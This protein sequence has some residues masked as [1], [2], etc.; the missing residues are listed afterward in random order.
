MARPSL[1][2]S[3]K[4][5]HGSRKIDDFFPR[6]SQGSMASLSQA[7][8]SQ[9]TASQSLGLSQAST[10]LSSQP[11]SQPRSKLNTT[12]SKDRKPS[13][14][15]A[16][17]RADQE[18]I[19]VS[20]SHSG[21]ISIS[22]DSKSHITVSSGSDPKSVIIISDSSSAENNK[23]LPNL[24][25]SISAAMA[26]K[27][28]AKE[29]PPT[30]TATSKSKS[31][32]S[33][34][35]NVLATT[36]SSA[37][38]TVRRRSAVDSSSA[39]A[40]LPMPRKRKQ[41]IYD[42]DSP[43][44]DSADGS[45]YLADPERLP[46]AISKAPVPLRREDFIP[47]SI[48]KP[49]DN[50]PSS[51]D[52]HVKS[53]RKSSTPSKRLRLS[54]PSPSLPPVNNDMPHQEHIPEVDLPPAHDMTCET[55]H[56]ASSGNEADEEE[57]PSSQSD[58]QELTLPKPNV[59]DPQEVKE[60][61]DHWRRT[62]GVSS[63]SGSM[64]TDASPPS[65]PPGLPSEPEQPPSSPAMGVDADGDVLQSFPDGEPFTSEAFATGYD[66]PAAMDVD[67][68]MPDAPHLVSELT[69]TIVH[70]HESEEEA[71]VSQQLQLELPASTSL[72]SL[73]TL[74][75]GDLRANGAGPPTTPPPP[76]SSSSV[77]IAGSGASPIKI[78]A[79]PSTPFKSKAISESPFKAL[80]DSPPSLRKK[81][82][83]PL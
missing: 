9:P 38:T 55:T 59:K 69:A 48:L 73:S 41:G 65:E 76:A 28:K 30:K 26:K 72:T 19:T 80:L 18:V 29:K 74:S 77:R 1:S 37:K 25:P 8:S 61:V 83:C 10:S 5:D 31:K 22:D 51:L 32:Q 23:A 20:D 52:D 70:E 35:S 7:S 4:V 44:S 34:K 67:V 75:S 33:E 14:N 56:T 16:P 71:E 2:Q 36:T 12:N 49:K 82:F 60:R 39:S 40:A 68:E 57:V 6:R 66:D 47:D 21:R 46:E 27:S 43:S 45:V 63:A 3:K 11:Q 42:F 17:P 13:K 64:G 62:S 79:A 53:S 24:L 15:N 58:E 78:E 54:P 50:T 81:K